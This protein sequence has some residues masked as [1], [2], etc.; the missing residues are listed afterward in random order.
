MEENNEILEYNCT[1]C[2][3]RVNRDDTMCPNCGAELEG[4]EDD[5]NDTLVEIKT[6]SNDIDAQLDKSLLE[7]EGI[8]CNLNGEKIAGLLYIPSVIRLVV[9]KRDVKRALEILGS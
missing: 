8:E 6:Y 1:N 9:L 4:F 7:A 5:D 2:G 3:T